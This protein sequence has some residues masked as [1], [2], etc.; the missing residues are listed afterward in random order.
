MGKR[1]VMGTSRVLVTKACEGDGDHVCFREVL[2]KDGE[3]SLQVAGR[4]PW[5]R[6][7][8]CPLQQLSS[9][10]LLSSAMCRQALPSTA[11]QAWGRTVHRT[12]WWEGTPPPGL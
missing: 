11:L 1:A 9:T 10:C 2:G 5:L 7:W 4:L 3:R 12:R 8:R 6:A